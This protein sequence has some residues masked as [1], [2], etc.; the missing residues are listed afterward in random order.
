MKHPTKKKDQTTRT[1]RLLWAA[2]TVALVVLIVVAIAPWQKQKTAVGEFVPPPFEPSAVAGLPEVDESLGWS[3]LAIRQGYAVKLCGEL[4]AN[5]D[6]TLPVWLY[7]DGDN[8]VWVKLRILSESGEILG[9][10]GL[11]RPGEYVELVQLNDAAASGPVTLH[12]MGY[13]PNTYYSA[14]A[15]DF[16]TVLNMAD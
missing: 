13:E 6:G 8:D 2:C 9:E 1:I 12:I 7:A 5:P 15:V 16:Q 3:E 11:L 4:H 14:G 10:S